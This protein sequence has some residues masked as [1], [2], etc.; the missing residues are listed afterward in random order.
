MNISPNSPASEQQIEN[1]DRFYPNFLLSTYLQEMQS[2]GHLAKES[3]KIALEEGISIVNQNL[4]RFKQHLIETGHSRLNREQ[5]LHYKEAVF[6]LARKKLNHFYGQ[7]RSVGDMEKA[8]K[9]LKE[10]TEYWH[11]RATFAIERVQGIVT[12][13]LGSQVI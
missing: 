9:T 1:F 10:Q 11:N 2:E 8:S 13:S 12:Q 7:T 4:S 5:S 6:A 3:I